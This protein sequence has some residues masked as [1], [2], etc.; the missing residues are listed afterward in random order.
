MPS[1]FEPCGLN[2]LFSMRYGTVPVAHATGGLRDTI[3]NYDPS[4]SGT[5]SS[6]LIASGQHMRARF[7]GGSHLTCCHRSSSAFSA[8]CDALTPP[9]P[10]MITVRDAPGY[11]SQLLSERNA[12]R[13]FCRGCTPPLVPAPALEQY[14]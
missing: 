8:L 7:S 10:A 12:S 4:A 5:Q 11:Q 6:L 13:A 14:S 2:Q 9:L 1:R 3:A